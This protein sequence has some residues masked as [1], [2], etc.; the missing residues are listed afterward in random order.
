MLNI[1]LSQLQNNTS[2]QIIALSDTMADERNILNQLQ[3]NH[4]LPLYLKPINCTNIS[5]DNLYQIQT[6]IQQISADLIDLNNTINSVEASITT[7]TNE[8]STCIQNLRL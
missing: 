2:I 6:S 3:Q 4:V 8:T 7:P 1:T 5:Q